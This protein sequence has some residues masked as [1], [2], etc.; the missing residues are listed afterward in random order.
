MELRFLITNHSD[1]LAHEMLEAP[2]D[3]DMFEKLRKAL[4]EMGYD[5]GRNGVSCYV[6]TKNGKT[7]YGE[8][9]V[10]A[11]GDKLKS[12]TAGEI[13]EVMDEFKHLAKDKHSYRYRATTAFL[14]ELPIRQVIYIHWH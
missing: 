10:D 1:A 7:A 9:K 2:V 6:A 3:Y 5:C 13:L 12:L 8:V 4:D 11:Y 14:R